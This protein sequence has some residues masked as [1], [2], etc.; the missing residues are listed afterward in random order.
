MSIVK[1]LFRDYGDFVVDIPEWQIADKGVTA[2][3]GPS[4]A[5]KTSAFRILTGLEPCPSLIWD[6]SG[7][8]IAKLPVRDRRLGVVFQSY[9]LF[10]HMTASENILF[11]AEA[12]GLK[13]SE[14]QRE[15]ARLTEELGLSPFLNTRAAVLSGGEKQRV[16]LGRALIGNPRF[17]LLDEP[18]SALDEDLKQG[19]RNLV[20]RV[21]AE[22]GLATLLITH[23]P[24]DRDELATQV[25]QIRNGRLT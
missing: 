23:D 5:G 24:R 9:E 19:A 13:A 16:A 17:L 15:L 25:S 22:R 8:D 10:P 7:E 12:R 18:F 4:G 20:K 14:R 21:I 1:N 2:L 11:A 3:W 6:F